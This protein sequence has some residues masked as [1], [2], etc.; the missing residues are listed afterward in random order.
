LLL[1]LLLLLWHPVKWRLL[2]LE[3]GQVHLVDLFVSALM[4]PFLNSALSLSFFTCSSLRV[5]LPFRPKNGP[6]V[7][8]AQDLGDQTKMYNS[9]A[10]RFLKLF[11]ESSLKAEVICRN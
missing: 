7:D 3:S 1:L 10:K 2:L 5:V 11:S 6:N 9:N 4:R 8:C